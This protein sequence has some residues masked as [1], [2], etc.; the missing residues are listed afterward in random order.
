MEESLDFE[1]AE[2][3]ARDLMA[4][5]DESEI[6]NDM[7][8]GGG[9]DP[10]VR[11]DDTQ[12]IR[13]SIRDS[14]VSSE[15]GNATLQQTVIRDTHVMNRMNWIMHLK[16]LF[17]EL[18]SF[19]QTQGKQKHVELANFLK[20][21]RIIKEKLPLQAKID[22]IRTCGEI[23]FSFKEVETFLSQGSQ[24][25]ITWD[26]VIDVFLTRSA[27]PMPVQTNVTTYVP[28]RGSHYPQASQYYSTGA[29]AQ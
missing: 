22:Y 11:D 6:F 2:K 8:E 17:D 1:G 13:E 23:A 15:A 25:Y 9:I 10:S 24:R 19:T 21:L 20:A 27:S 5:L 28:H 18:E 29:P 26:N 3:E 7:L 4:E 16:I 14:I 12:S